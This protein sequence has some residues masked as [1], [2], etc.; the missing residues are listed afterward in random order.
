MPTYIFSAIF[1]RRDDGRLSN[2]F[3]LFWLCVVVHWPPDLEAHFAVTPKEGGVC[4]QDAFR[5]DDVF[6]QEC[7]ARD[8]HSGGTAFDGVADAEYVIHIYVTEEK[9]WFQHSTIGAKM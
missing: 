3:K 4:E 6:Q 9:D 8:V 5:H 2:Q 1:D 7:R